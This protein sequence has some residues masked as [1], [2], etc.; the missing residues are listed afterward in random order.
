MSLHYRGV[1]YDHV[2]PS[3]ET[4]GASIVGHYRGATLKIRQP[5]TSVGQAPTQPLKYRGAWVR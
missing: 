1:E 4:T 3:M 2:S 5:R